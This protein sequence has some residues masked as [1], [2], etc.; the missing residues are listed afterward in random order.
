MTLKMGYGDG[1]I[2]ALANARM[3]AI[4]S[5]DTNWVVSVN[6]PIDSYEF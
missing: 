3:D 4:Y 1:F 5:A 2:F 6:L